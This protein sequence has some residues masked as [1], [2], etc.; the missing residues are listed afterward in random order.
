MYVSTLPALFKLPAQMI[1]LAGALDKTLQ[2]V[3]SALISVIAVEPSGEAMEL[4][5]P[6]ELL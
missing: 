1:G 4:P 2:Y 6:R 5:L 3:Y